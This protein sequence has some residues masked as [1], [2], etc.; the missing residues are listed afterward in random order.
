LDPA[1]KQQVVNE[2]LPYQH[3]VKIQ[4]ILQTV[5]STH[6]NNDHR[7]TMS[8]WLEQFASRRGLDLT[9]YPKTFLDWL[10]Q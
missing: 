4:Q 9:I 6:V 7:L 2:L 10:N 8:A 3:D 1:S 5:S